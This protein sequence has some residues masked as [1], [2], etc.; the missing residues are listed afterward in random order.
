MCQSHKWFRVNWYKF[1]LWY[2][3]Q[4]KI[5]WLLTKLGMVFIS[6]SRQAT[7]TFKYQGRICR[8][9]FR[10][11]HIPTQDD[12]Q[13][14]KYHLQIMGLMVKFK[15]WLSILNRSKNVRHDCSLAD[16]CFPNQ[17]RTAMS[18]ILFY[19]SQVFD[20]LLLVSFESR[21]GRAAQLFWGN[22]TLVLKRWEAPGKNRFSWN[23]KDMHD[24]EL[25][26]TTGSELPCNF[27]T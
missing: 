24:K 26:S 1:T 8:E 25:W 21:F 11:R 23:N 9:N 14:P 6:D 7:V 5:G 4:S 20:E 22:D 17:Y 2:Q 13:R 19:Q 12:C 10:H 16:V 27:N 18:L 15:S 3:S